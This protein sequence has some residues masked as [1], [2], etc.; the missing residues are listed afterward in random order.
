MNELQEELPEYQ[1]FTILRQGEKD[2][3]GPFSQ[4][5]IVSLLNQGQIRSVDLVYYDGIG[6]WRPLSEVFE[7]HQAIG[8]YVDEGQDREIVSDVFGALS[9]MLAERESIYYIAVQ[10]WPALKLRKPDSVALT[11]GAIYVVHHRR[12]TLEVEPYPWD[13]VFSVTARM[14]VGET[15]G[16]LAILLQN[17]SRIEV[18]RIPRAQLARA[19]QIAS[20]M[21]GSAAL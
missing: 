15:D 18:E 14:R 19:E 10:E 16:T 3:I 8:N 9:E 5:Q 2:P 21:M 17:A 1:I 20:D 11:E 12:G 6:E 4:N 13:K 7:L